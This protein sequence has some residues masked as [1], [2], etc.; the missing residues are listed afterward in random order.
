MSVHRLIG[1]WH[2]FTCT[3]LSCSMV[4]AHAQQKAASTLAYVHVAM[5]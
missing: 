2:A 1:C 5:T 3:G 4:S